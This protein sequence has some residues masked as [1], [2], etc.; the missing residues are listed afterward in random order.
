MSQEL[1]RRI[2]ERL[3]DTPELVGPTETDLRAR[4]TEFIRDEEPL[5][6]STKFEKLL[7]E[8]TDEVAGLGSLE[9]FLADPS[10]TE[11][12]LNGPG[13]AFVEREGQLT[14]IP[15]ALEA[16]EIMRLVERIVGPL[17]LR[18]DRS[19]PIVDARL[20]DGSRLHAVI[21]PLALDGPYVTIRRFG[22]RAV[23]LSAF[24]LGEDGIE[25][26][27]WAV[28]AGW[29]L[30]VAGATSAG[31]TTLLNALSAA[32][33][34][35]ERVVTIEETAELRL[36][37]PHVVRL[38]ARP[39]NAEGAG[40]VS[41][42]DLVRASLRM[43][44]DRI[45]VGEVRGGEALDMLQALN[46]GHDGSLTTVHANGASEALTRIETLALMAN[47][48]LPLEAVRAQI[49]S[50][51]DAVIFVS[52]RSQGARAVDEIAELRPGIGGPEVAALFARSGGKLMSV[53]R[54]TR[55]LRR[56]EAGEWEA[57]E[58][59]ARGSEVRDSAARDLVVPS[60]KP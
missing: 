16:S 7:G 37:Q 38:E 35:R 41:L 31:K 6:N 9:P 23:D 5:L 44:P 18:L 20:A 27:T 55:R 49:L 48:G 25:F 59:E 42:R 39:A 53:G 36:V 28:R 8:L 46:T 54:P 21:P 47:I 13:R 57:R 17:G 50:A 34:A 4:L 26:L 1:K 22:A 52:R 14:A 60:I 56:P 10:V 15:L 45:V 29:N 51:I 3:I 30:L 19:S 58:W 33:P 12:M 2:H 24:D 40:G 32:I 43:R 11:I